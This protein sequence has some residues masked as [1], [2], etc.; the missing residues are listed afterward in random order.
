MRRQIK[1]YSKICEYC[2]K[3]LLASKKNVKY[4][5]ECRPQNRNNQIKFNCEY[6]GKISS[7]AKGQYNRSKYHY[8][9]QECKSKH[10][11]EILKG[12]NNPNY[13]SKSYITKCTYCGKEYFCN[14]YRDKKYHYCSQECKSKHQKEILKGENNPNYKSI[15]CL[16]GYCRKY[17]YRTPNY[18]SLHNN[19]FCSNECWYKWMS[20]NRIGENSPNY[21]SNISQE[22]REKGR[23][24]DGYNNFI[25]SVYERDNYTCQ[26]C[27]DKRGGN[28]VAH[29]LNGYNWD[30]EHRTDVNNGITLC[31]TCHKKF[32][33]QYGYGNNTKGQFE[34]FMNNRNNKSV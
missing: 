3:F 5:V 20:K 24:I 17:I 33:K 23:I 9:S 32:H 21:D 16:C 8:C 26:C 25:K 34:E 7:Q 18:I 4:H 11:K 19:V 6:C 10:Q 14:D 1:K 2:G 15:K 22:D 29:H 12:E 30:K 27:G 31:E 28:L 13:K